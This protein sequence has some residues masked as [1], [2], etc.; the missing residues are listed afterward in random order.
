MIIYTDYSLALRLS[1]FEMAIN[2][3]PMK[4][5]MRCWITPAATRMAVAEINRHGTSR[6]YKT[7]VLKL[8]PMITTTIPSSKSAIAF[9][10]V[11]VFINHIDRTLR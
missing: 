5:P 1:L 8:D 7:K 4:I 9:K 10:I 6:P 11:L 3:N 2:N